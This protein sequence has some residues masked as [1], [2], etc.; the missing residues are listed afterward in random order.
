MNFLV[1]RL[2]Y[3]I[4]V[5]VVL[6][7]SYIHTLKPKAYIW[8]RAFMEHFDKQIIT[9]YMCMNLYS[10]YMYKPTHPLLYKKWAQNKF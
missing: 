4:C 7:V 10:N 5:T 3:I 9:A 6:H 2:L 1:E 8:Q